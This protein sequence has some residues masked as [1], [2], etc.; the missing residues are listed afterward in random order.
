VTG[1]QNRVEAGKKQLYY[2]SFDDVYNCR[3]CVVDEGSSRE[4]PLWSVLNGHHPKE[5]TFAFYFRE[6]SSVIFYVER[7]VIRT[8]RRYL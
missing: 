4:R 7:H 3:R 2:K 6:E 1:I 8:L 5:E